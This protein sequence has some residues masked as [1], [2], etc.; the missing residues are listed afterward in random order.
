MNIC[1][2]GVENL[3]VGIVMGAVNDYCHSLDRIEA[4]NRKYS[5]RKK[6]NNG[7]IKEQNSKTL[8]RGTGRNRK[9]TS[10]NC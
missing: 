9:A 1:D 8:Y 3:R 7:W 5:A 10:D 2:A 4:L 6:N